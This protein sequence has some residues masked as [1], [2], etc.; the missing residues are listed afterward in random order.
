MS[1]PRIPVELVA[2]MRL[3]RDPQKTLN[4][5]LG[6]LKWHGCGINDVGAPDP[7]VL[8]LLEIAR[9]V[10]EFDRRQPKRTTGVRV[11]QVHVTM[12]L[13]FPGR[14][15]ASA[16]ADLCELLRIQ[17]NSQWIFNFKKRRS[18]KSEADS[19]FAGGAMAGRTTTKRRS[20]PQPIPTRQAVALFSGGLDSTCGL[21]ELSRQ[22][23][24]T[25]L[26]GY[27]TRNRQKQDRIAKK[28]GFDHFAQITSEWPVPRSTGR[29][30]GQF[31]YRSF[32]FLSLAAVLA[33]ATRA[34]S[35]LQFENGPLALAVPPLDIY[36]ITRHAHPLVHFHFARLFE[37]LT[38]RTLVVSNPFLERTKGEAVALL[39]RHLSPTAFKDVIGDTESCWYL[40]SRTIVA[41]PARKKNGQP[42]GAC[43]PCLVRRA[44]LGADDIK[45]GVD[46]KA[47]RGRATRDPVVRVHYEAY[48]AFAQRLLATGYGLNDFVEEVP[49]ATRMALR[50]ANSMS[51]ETAFDLYRRFAREWL[52]AFA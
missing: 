40:N 14:W 36:R 2:T 37:Q 39:R 6:G 7:S 41:G 32:F 18:G 33:D 10:H 50:G 46:F 29:T 12:P 8:D 51:P 45:A 31:L 3:P 17:G 35:L 23:D 15:T 28:L 5:D 9:V 38:G 30:G 27:Y 20:S 24:K 19:F 22:A 13:R 26:V 44:A 16:K 48:S 1:K 42:C 34:P 49:A 11:K 52:K 21:A 43:V 25:L 4:L 47:G